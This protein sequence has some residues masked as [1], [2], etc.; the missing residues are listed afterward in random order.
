MASK[1]TEQPKSSSRTELS[2]GRRGADQRREKAQE[3][4]PIKPKQPWTNKTR[5]NE[6]GVSR[7]RTRIPKIATFDR[8]NHPAR[9][10]SRTEKRQGRDLSEET[11]RGAWGGGAG[12]S[13]IRT[14]ARTSARFGRPRGEA[15]GRAAITGRLASTTADDCRRRGGR[16]TAGTQ[17]RSD[18]ERE[19]RAEMRFTG[20]TL[21]ERKRQK[22]RRRWNG[23]RG[24]PF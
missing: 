4:N 22:L 9:A 8:K 14:T 23:F 1:D 20:E 13:P 17:L 11:I 19:S 12:G 7:P 10:Q 15:R 21:A 2:K 3:L 24:G 16:S 6:S 5:S 18:E